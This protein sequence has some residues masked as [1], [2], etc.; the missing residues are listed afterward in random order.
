MKK[1]TS[2]VCAIALTA[3][4]A[5]T[6]APAQACVSNCNRKAAP[7]IALTVLAFLLI[8]N[9]GGSAGSGLFS[10]KSEPAKPPKGKVLQKF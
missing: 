4:L 1:V 8:A 6:P 10:S 5:V 7:L 3:S 9:S 2:F